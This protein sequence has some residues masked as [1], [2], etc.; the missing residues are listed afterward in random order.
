MFLQGYQDIVHDGTQYPGI[1]LGMYTGSATVGRMDIL[2]GT[3]TLIEIG[4]KADGSAAIYG[5]GHW[6]GDVRRSYLNALLP[7]VEG[8]EQVI[9]NGGY[10]YNR[11]FHDGTTST[12]P[13]TGIVR[14]A[15]C[16][17]GTVTSLT[18]VLSYVLAHAAVLT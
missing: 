7:Q 9:G 15:T 17:F 16:N 11:Q 5:P 3:C 2:G 12:S 1:P 4:G 10:N 13:S 8:Q 18:N 14:H 6:S